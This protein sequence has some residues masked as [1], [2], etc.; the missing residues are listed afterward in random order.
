MQLPEEVASGK[1]L[2]PLRSFS[3]KCAA[4]GKMLLAFFEIANDSGYCESFDMKKPKMLLCSYMSFSY[5]KMYS[6]PTIEYGNC[7][8]FPWDISL[9]PVRETNTCKT[10]GKRR[11]RERD[12]VLFDSEGFLVSRI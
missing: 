3:C 5:E 1:M 7:I 8:F 10:E 2:L 4:F 12:A 6:D 11:D 9:Q